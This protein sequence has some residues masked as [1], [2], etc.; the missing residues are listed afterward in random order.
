MRY[1]GRQSESLARALYPYGAGT[2]ESLAD[3]IADLPGPERLV[4]ALYY[5]ED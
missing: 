2:H 5:C 3:A 1:D 4:L